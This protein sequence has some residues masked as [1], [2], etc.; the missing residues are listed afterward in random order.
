MADR[1]PAEDG[2]TN[3]ANHGGSGQNVLYADGH[4]IFRVTRTVAGDDIYLNRDQQ[5]AAGLGATD[6]VLGA[7]AARP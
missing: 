4:V 5:V 1:A 2:R 3:S 7:S 6:A